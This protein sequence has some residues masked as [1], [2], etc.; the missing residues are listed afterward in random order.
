MRDGASFAE[1]LDAHLGCTNVPPPPRAWSTRP[2]T[3]PLFAF[4][5]PL[6][7]TPHAAPSVASSAPPRNEP[8]APVKV[9]LTVL[10]RRAFDALNALGAGLDDSFTA[11]TLRRAFRTLA[12]RYHPDR[13]P[14]STAGER[15]RLARFFAEATDHYRL[16]TRRF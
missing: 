1:M 12:H 15:E 16:L 11:A 10:E 2:L 9:D 14:G 6:E 5:F 8:P 13:H 7:T 3:A 4:E